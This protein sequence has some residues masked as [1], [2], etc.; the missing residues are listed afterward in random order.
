MLT[1]TLMRVTYP[2]PE[3]SSWY[4]DPNGTPSYRAYPLPQS[5]VPYSPIPAQYSPVPHVPAA[6]APAPVVVVQQPPASGLAV[7]SMVLGIV[8]LVSGCC[9]F[10]IFSILAV[11]LG[12][13]GMAE[14]RD[15][16]KSGRGMA[17]A[18]L[19]MGYVLVGPAIAVSILVVFGSGLTALTG[20]AAP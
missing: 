10:G 2:Q 11:I 3:S 14:T 19:V 16:R 12:H 20:G 9:T 4:D 6:Y 15:G 17:Q 5:S 8:G 7:A 18:G 13:A 1:V